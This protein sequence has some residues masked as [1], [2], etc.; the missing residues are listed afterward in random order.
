MISVTCLG[1]I[2]CLRPSEQSPNQF[3]FPSVAVRSA[4]FAFDEASLLN[5]TISPAR[6]VEL[7][8]EDEE[9]VTWDLLACAASLSLLHGFVRIR[10]MCRRR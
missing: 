1:A 6:S 8:D 3:T 5:S 4:R 10:G 9:E 7:D 2:D